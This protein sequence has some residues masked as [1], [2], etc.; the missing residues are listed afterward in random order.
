MHQRQPS[1]P[2][3]RTSSYQQSAHHSTA[4]LLPRQL[5]F[6]FFLSGK[7]SE[8]E[9]QNWNVFQ[10][11]SIA[12]VRAYPRKE[13]K[14]E[15]T[16]RNVKA[17]GPCSGGHGCV[18]NLQQST[19]SSAEH[20]ACVGN[21]LHPTGWE[22]RGKGWRTGGGL[23]SCIKICLKMKPAVGNLYAVSKHFIENNFFK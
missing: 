13:A 7:K 23:I 2:C 22:G 14:A 10:H 17:S 5:S 6:L 8:V 4:Q 3:I 9:N 15:P 18:G 21:T 19:W 12:S 20:R 16:K 11:N 1:S